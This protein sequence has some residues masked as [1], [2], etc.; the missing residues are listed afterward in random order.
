MKNNDINY[1]LTGQAGS[2]KTYT[3]RAAIYKLFL[4]HGKGRVAVIAPT[5]AAS[6]GAEGMT[7]HRFLHLGDGII[8]LNTVSLAEMVEHIFFNQNDRQRDFRIPNL[9]KWKKVEVIV[10]D[11]VSMLC[12]QAF[13]TLDKL[14]SLIKA[15]DVDSLHQNQSYGSFNETRT[16]PPKDYLNG[17][18]TMSPRYHNINHLF[19]HFL[20]DP[21]RLDVAFGGVKFIGCGDALQIP[22]IIEGDRLDHRYLFFFQAKVSLERLH[23]VGQVAVFEVCYLDTNYRQE[24]TDDDA[25]DYLFL[26]NRLRKGEMS[27]EDCRRFN[28]LTGRMVPKEIFETCFEVLRKSIESES[29]ALESRVDRDRFLYPER[30]VGKLWCP[31]ILVKRI[32]PCSTAEEVQRRRTAKIADVVKNV[33]DHWKHN[34]PKAVIQDLNR[35]ELGRSIIQEP[36]YL[37]TENMEKRALGTIDVSFPYL[38][39]RTQFEARDSPPHDSN[40]NFPVD[41]TNWKSAQ[42]LSLYEGQ[43]IT[44]VSNNYQTRPYAANNTFG[45]ITKIK[46]DDQEIL[47]RPTPSASRTAGIITVGMEDIAEG[48][49]GA[50]KGRRRQL[51]VIPS[52]AATVH[53]VQGQTYVDIPT[54]FVN[55]RLMKTSYSSFYVAASRHT[56]PKYFKTLFPIVEGENPVHPAALAWDNHHS[57]PKNKNQFGI[58]KVDYDRGIFQGWVQEQE[59]K[60][61]R[62]TQKRKG[63]EVAAA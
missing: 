61:A 52:V 36:L 49:Y 22:P 13:D 38:H 7:I 18:E 33:E 1:I 26:L 40:N 42:T 17:A 37:V 41:I 31:N 32:G 45:I 14:F 12:A 21:H 35:E 29:A 57:D 19:H 56:H 63:R 58:S 62:Q 60:M 9:I 39:P 6:V 11:E 5:N 16:N 46:D 44:F 47:V 24:V 43:R 15:V 20:R 55:Q 51:P 59:Q 53:V 28:Q 50:N 30:L 23:Q 3:L 4:K 25:A 34:Q 54:V 10:Y 48:K 8:D 2:G 27:A